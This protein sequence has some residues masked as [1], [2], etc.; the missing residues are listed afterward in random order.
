[1]DDSPQEALEHAEQA[2]HAADEGDAFSIRV[3][4]TIALLAVGAA[5]IGSLE[6][7]ETAKTLGDKNDAALIQNR[8]TDQWSFFQA[9]SIKKN[10]YEIASMAGGLHADEFA[11]SAKRNDEESRQIQTQATD[12]ETQVETKLA[13]SEI[14]EHRHQSLTIALT[15]LHVAIAVGTVSLILRKKRWPWYAA[16]AL[17]VIGLVATGVAYV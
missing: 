11:A 14:H 15:M 12:L 1:M 5:S 6:A 17:G 13:S 9:K 10:M 7:L 8:A 4:V 16:I 2:R 3:A